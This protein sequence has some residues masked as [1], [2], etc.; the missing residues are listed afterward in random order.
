MKQIL[1]FFVF[2]FSILNSQTLKKVKI[3]DAET[4]KAI[5]NV[6]IILAD[7]I[8]YSNDDGSISLP[9]DAKQ[10]EVSFTGYE[11][12]KTS[13]FQSSIKLKPLYNDIDEVKIVSVDIKKIFTDVSKNYTNRYYDKPAIFDVTY[14][15]KRFENNKMKLLVVADGKFWTR[16]GQYNAKEA[17]NG[18]H[19]NFVQLQIDTLRYLKLENNDFNI[20]VKPQKVSHQPVGSMFFDYELFYMMRRSKNK[21]AVTSG[22]LLYENEFEQEISYKIKMT[23]NITYTGTFRYNKADKV[24]T[25]F[26]MN[27]KQSNASLEV[28]K[29]EDGFEY[30]RQSPDGTYI[31]EFYKSGEKYVPSKISIRYEGIKYAMGDKVFEY[32]NARDI[33]FKSFKPTEERG[34]QNPVDINGYFWKNMKISDDKGLVNLSEEE[35]NFINDKADEN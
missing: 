30:Q 18:K 15:Q 2:S 13:K 5:P 35:L 29:D 8:F 32:R 22:K 12:L 7:Q 11:T 23:D 6:R 28:F 1:L 10:F 24:I 27:F 14:S 9:K 33:I 21:N 17:F 20:K 19:K 3:E 26:E 31:F 34:V 4:G 16:D 25:L